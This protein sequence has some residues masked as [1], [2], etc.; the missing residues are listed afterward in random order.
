[1]RRVG[2]TRRADK[3]RILVIKSSFPS[4]LQWSYKTAPAGS[5]PY[6]FSY[7]GVIKTAKGSILAIVVAMKRVDQDSGSACAPVCRAIL[8]RLVSV[9]IMET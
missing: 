4:S 3:N 8:S 9:F 6:F 5:E 7:G 1:M 2:L